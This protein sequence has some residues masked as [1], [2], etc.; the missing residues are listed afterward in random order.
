[1]TIVIMLALG[2]GLGVFA[3]LHQPGAPLTFGG[4]NT[5]AQALEPMKLN[6]PSSLKLFNN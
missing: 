3:V 2:L 5:T 1:M 4:A 6:D